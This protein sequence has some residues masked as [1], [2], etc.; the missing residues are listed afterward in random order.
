M[1]ISKLIIKSNHAVPTDTIIIVFTGYA[2]IHSAQ[3]H[4]DFKR[5][6]NDNFEN[7]DKHFYI[8]KNQKSYHK[9][10]S[11]ISN[12]IDETV[13]YLKNIIKNYTK[14]IFM[15][16]SSGGYA[17]ILFGSLLNATRV[18]AFI[19]QTILYKNDPD[20]NEKY[21]DIEPFINKISKYY[22][23]GDLSIKNKQN[24]HHISHCERIN[25]Y[26]NVFLTEFDNLNIKVL[27]NN[28]IL[29]KIIND[30]IS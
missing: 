16:I 28:G 21:R 24:C 18:L 2:M 12:N 4:F 20:Y 25:K 11:G 9:G 30:I 29:L 26:S 6:L 5:I 8:D 13:E 27:R 22:I 14:T 23:Y 19:P 17:A 15:G 7:I 10:I 3:Q 1:S